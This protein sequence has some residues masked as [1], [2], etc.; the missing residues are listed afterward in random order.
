M[1]PTLGGM[2]SGRFG[3][4][5]DAMAD[6]TIRLTAAVTRDDG[7]YV[8]RCLEVEV[9]SQGRTIDE[10]LANL[11][12]ALELYFED[13]PVPETSEAIVAPVEVKLSA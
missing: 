13:E 4:S 5:I 6:R 11:R 7:W 3:G 2:P 1:G 8:A 9:A 12:E 10:A